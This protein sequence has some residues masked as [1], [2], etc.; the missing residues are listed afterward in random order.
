[1]V[2]P[3]S[4]VCDLSDLDPLESATSN[5]ADS[6][7]L[8]RTSVR[9]GRPGSQVPPGVEALGRPHSWAI[10]GRPCDRSLTPIAL[11]RNQ[12]EDLVPSN[13]GAR[14]SAYG[15]AVR[16]SVETAVPAESIVTTRIVLPMTSKRY[17]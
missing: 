10:C 14:Q 13:P 16:V 6:L 15:R 2:W 1:M 12:S 8:R 11:G 5:H 3:L 17:Q 4:R 9:F 7:A